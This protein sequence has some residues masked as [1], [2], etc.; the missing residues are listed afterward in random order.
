MK[1]DRLLAIIIMLLNRNR[2]QA[3]DLADHFEVST[4]T[5]YRDIETIKLININIYKEVDWIL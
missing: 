2:V 3:R 4:R 1:I 5:I